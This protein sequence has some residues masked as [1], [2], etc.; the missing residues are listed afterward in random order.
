MACRLLVR[1]ILLLFQKDIKFECPEAE[2]SWFQFNHK[3]IKILN[4]SKF[5]SSNVDK[6]LGNEDKLLIKKQNYNIL[7]C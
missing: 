5:L 2:V 3:A 7:Y 6:S 4:A 1:L